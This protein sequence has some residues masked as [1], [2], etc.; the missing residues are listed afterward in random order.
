RLLLRRYAQWGLST[1]PWAGYAT[2][3]TDPNNRF[4]RL[5]SRL[6]TC[7]EYLQFVEDQGYTTLTLPQGVLD[8]YVAGSANRHDH[9]RHFTRCLKDHVLVTAGWPS[10]QGETFLSAM[11]TGE[12]W[13]H[14]RWLIG[15]EPIKAQDRVA[16]LFALLYGQPISR[17][18]TIPRSA[19]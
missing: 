5:R 4:H 1:K 9:I 11:A 19:V 18:V 15:D 6:Q 3:P 2:R 16:G 10:R 13:R 14:A 8:A 7:A 17:I 12:R